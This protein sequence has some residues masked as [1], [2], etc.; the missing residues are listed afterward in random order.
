MLED[1]I[2]KNRIRE[3]RYNHAEK[4]LR[5][6]RQKIFDYEDAGLA[7]YEKAKK[8]MATCQRIVAP[9]YKAIREA[10]EFAKQNQYM[11]TME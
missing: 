7:V 2:K 8:V 3:A 4:I 10:R 11:R 9:R 5:K 1:A 6:I